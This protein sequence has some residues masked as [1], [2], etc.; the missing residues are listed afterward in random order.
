MVNAD[1]QVIDAEGAP[2]QDLYIAKE[3]LGAAAISE[4][5]RM[6]SAVE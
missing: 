4:K 5:V 3:I 2:I 6:R 1:V